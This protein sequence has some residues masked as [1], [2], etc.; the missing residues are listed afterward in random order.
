MRSPFKYHRVL[1]KSNETNIR[2]IT[3]ETE[4]QPG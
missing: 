4:S 2:T 3:Q 1:E